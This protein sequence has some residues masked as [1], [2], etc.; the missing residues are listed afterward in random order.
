MAHRDIWSNH[1][2]NADTIGGENKDIEPMTNTV[3]RSQA[4]AWTL[5]AQL[6][7]AVF[8][9]GAV[10]LGVVGLPEPKSATL[11]DPTNSDT[12]ANMPD[13]GGNTNNNPDSNAS[14][15]HSVQIDTLGLAQR[16]ALLDNAPIAAGTTPDQPEPSSDI[17]T[18]ADDGEIAKRVRYIGFI[19]DPDS[20]HAFIRI[21][22]KQRIVSLGQ[23]A[24]A[25]NPDFPDL[26]V[27]RITPEHIVMTD[28]EQ[29]A[30]IQ[31]ANRSGQSIT[32]A[33][34]TQIEIA[35]AAENGSLLTAEDEAMIAALQPRLR[36]PTRRRLERE[37]RGLPPTKE[38]RRPTP[39][40]LGTFRGGFSKNGQERNKNNNQSGN[41]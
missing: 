33:G 6:A 11:L 13:M 27:E 23:I 5:G 34:G 29:R 10:A 26:T 14:A 8:V 7:S 20:R 30:R 12:F 16:L 24:R 3:S 40:P 36:Q 22:G 21:D 38:R 15:V 4:K 31:L 32:M 19:N 41:D 39:E 17:D 9:L 28:G 2:H 1:R 18:T 35:P 25:G 37:R